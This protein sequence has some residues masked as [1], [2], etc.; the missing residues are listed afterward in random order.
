MRPL[1]SGLP[2]VSPKPET[3]AKRHWQALH[4]AIT[5]GESAGLTR[6][7]AESMLARLRFTERVA[8]SKRQNISPNWRLQQH[9]QAEISG[10]FR[11][12]CKHSLNFRLPGAGM[13]RRIVRTT[14]QRL[15]SIQ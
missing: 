2:L 8:T 10:R 4:Q 12:N 1:L 9:K 6:V 11:N 15:S 3:I 7:L 14:E 13:Q 5:I